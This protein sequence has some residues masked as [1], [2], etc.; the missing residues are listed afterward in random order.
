MVSEEA[1]SSS[2]CARLWNGDEDVATP[3]PFSL[4]AVSRWA[5]S[6]SGSSAGSNRRLHFVFDSDAD[7]DPD[8][9]AGD[10]DVATPFPVWG[11]VRI[12]RS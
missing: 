8:T 6:S 11:W 9:D 4:E 7:T 10:E 5:S 2:P 1:K 3:K 12:R